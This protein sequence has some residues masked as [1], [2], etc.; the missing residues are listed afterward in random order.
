MYLALWLCHFLVELPLIAML[1]KFINGGLRNRRAFVF[2]QAQA[3]PTDDLPSPDQSVA[4]AMGK[5]LGAGHASI[6]EHNEN[7]G[8]VLWDSW[9]D[10]CEST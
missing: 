9:F 7:K 10:P 8:K 4:D 1:A 3:Q 6:K 2:G 5:M